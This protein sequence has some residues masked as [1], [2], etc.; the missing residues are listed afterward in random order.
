MKTKTIIQ[1]YFKC[2]DCV[3]V[4]KEELRILEQAPE[5]IKVTKYGELSKSQL[6]IEDVHIK[7]L[8]KRRDLEKEILEY[9]SFIAKVDAILKSLEHKVGKSEYE[10]FRLK[11]LNDR[12]LDYL[13]AKYGYAHASSIHR[14]LKKQEQWFEEIFNKVN[15]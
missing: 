8:D 6:D 9:Q 4:S 10:I 5:F 13:A 14:K 15:D 12:T 1:E 3:K 7:I 11:Y 2:K